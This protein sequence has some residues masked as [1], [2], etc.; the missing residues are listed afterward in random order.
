MTTTASPPRRRK[1]QPFNPAH[2]RQAR[3]LL[4]NAQV[5]AVEVDDPMALDPGD[6]IVVLRSTRDDPLAEMLARGQ[7]T[8][9]DFAA[10]R[11][12]QRA[13]EGSEI[14]GVCGID[15]TKEA[16][17]GGRMKD[18]ISERRDQAGRELKL[19]RDKLKASNW[20]VVAVLGTRK[21]LVDVA[22]ETAPPGGFERVYKALRLEFH[23]ALETLAMVFGYTS[24]TR[25]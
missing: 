9:C 20:L 1:A 7:I 6:K 3:D 22:R 11:H 19:A 21:A 25:A 10:G 16:V 5:A 2:D 13:Y 4:R 18:P 8:E 23:A 17:D 12:W 15:P 24:K 14:G